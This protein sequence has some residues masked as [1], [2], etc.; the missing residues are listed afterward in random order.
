MATT[1]S[2]RARDGLPALL[3]IRDVQ[4]G[5]RIS[6][7]TVYKLIE[8]GALHKIKIGRG[9]R[10]RLSDVEALLTDPAP[11]KRNP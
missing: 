6:R 3:T 2:Q 8:D 5:L 10:F 7:P 4:D 11:E 1:E 9:V